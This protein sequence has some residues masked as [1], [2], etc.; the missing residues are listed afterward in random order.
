MVSLKLQKRLAASVMNCGKGKVWLDPN[1]VSEISMANSR[2]NIRKLVKDGFIIRKPTKIHSRSRARR[3]NI[4][5][6]K[7]RHSGYGKRLSVRRMIRVYGS[8]MWCCLFIQM[9][10]DVGLSLLSLQEKLYQW[11][12]Q[13]EEER[14]RLT[15]VDI[16]AYIQNEIECEL[17]DPPVSPRVPSYQHPQ[18]DMQLNN[19]TASITGAATL[20]QAACSGQVNQQAKKSIFSNTQSTS[21][22]HSLQNLTTEVSYNS[23]PSLPTGNTNGP[24]HLHSKDKD[25][26]LSSDSMDMHAD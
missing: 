24:N 8:N 20:G 17:E 10:K 2:Q 6:M 11:I 14:S 12:L 16:Q 4:A 25:P 13:Q 21:I 1:E 9:V 15:P 7:G 26:P 5:K 22:C 19:L 18:V 23:S 3:M